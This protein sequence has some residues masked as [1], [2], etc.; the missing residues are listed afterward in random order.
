MEDYQYMTKSKKVTETTIK[1]LD[2]GKK[3]YI[4]MKPYI[5][6]DGKMFNGKETKVKSVTTE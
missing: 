6:I 5:K 4:T 2:S 1:N 3:Y